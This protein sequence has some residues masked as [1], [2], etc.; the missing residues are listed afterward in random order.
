MSGPFQV[1]RSVCGF[2]FA[3]TYRLI[4]LLPFVFSLLRFLYPSSHVFAE[5]LEPVL[6]S[7]EL[8]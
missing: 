6:M 5:H 4:V 7:L 8:Y 1:V 3:C 2:I